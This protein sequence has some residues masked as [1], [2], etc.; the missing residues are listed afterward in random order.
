MRKLE[1]F[2]KKRRIWGLQNLNRIK[3]QR[4]EFDPEEEVQRNGRGIWSLYKNQKEAQRSGFLLERRRSGT[5][6]T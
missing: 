2:C 5:N 6:E 4:S 3:I 1:I